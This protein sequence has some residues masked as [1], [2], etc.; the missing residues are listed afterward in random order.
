VDPPFVG[1]AVNVTDVP[2]QTFVAD[3]AIDTEGTTVGFTV[4]VIL[5]LFAVV[6]LAQVA[7]EVSTQLT[8]CPFVNVVVVKMLELVPA[9][10]PFTFH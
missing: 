7:F 6:G 2:A 9:F 5:A 4:I 10:V 8:A 1:V 3:A